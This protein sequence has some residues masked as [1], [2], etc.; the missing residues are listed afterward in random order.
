M[1]ALS[2]NRKSVKIGIMVYPNSTTFQEQAIDFG[3]P[4]ESC[5][6]LKTGT[7]SIIFLSLAIYA[8][9]CQDTENHP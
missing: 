5:S 4:K 7:Y 9:S 3:D 8:V 6:H 1:P 2:D